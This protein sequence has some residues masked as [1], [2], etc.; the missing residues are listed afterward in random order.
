MEV[1]GK[2]ISM[3]YVLHMYVLCIIT[4][5]ISLHAQKF[6]HFNISI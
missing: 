2:W 1:I 3:N 4:N 6:R 5:I